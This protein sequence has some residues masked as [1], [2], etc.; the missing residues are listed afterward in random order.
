MNRNVIKVLA[1]ILLAIVLVATTVTIANATSEYKASEQNAK[2]MFQNATDST[3]TSDAATSI[4]GSIITIVQIIGV[5]VAIIM[6]IVLAIKY[7]SAAPGD[8]AEIKKHAVVYVVGAIVLFAA[9]GIL[10]IIKNFASAFSVGNENG[11][12]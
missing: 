9:S 10:G 2:D 5:G 6:L 11:M 1:T 12:G 3:G 8:K 7:I 4:I